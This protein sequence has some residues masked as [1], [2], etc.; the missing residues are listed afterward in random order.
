[1][2]L[3]GNGPYPNHNNMMRNYCLP[4]QSHLCIENYCF[5]TLVVASVVHYSTENSA[6]KR[7]NVEK[8]VVDGQKK[9]DR[10]TLSPTVKH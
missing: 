1:L 10:K 8:I 2:T 9:C 7:H 3:N 4:I 5:T 6:M